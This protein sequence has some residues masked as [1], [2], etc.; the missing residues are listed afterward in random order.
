M[1]TKPGLQQTSSELK[2]E[3]RTNPTLQR[4]YLGRFVS[5][6]T[7]F[8]VI[9]CLT[10]WLVAFFVLKDS[11][12]VQAYLGNA[13]DQVLCITFFSGLIVAVLLG[14]LVGNIA[15]RIFWGMMIRRQ[16]QSE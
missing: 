8:V 14:S 6:I 5:M 15:R 4:S 7:F 11:V 1:A 12:E 3:L 16:R 13:L 10:L 2:D 9:A